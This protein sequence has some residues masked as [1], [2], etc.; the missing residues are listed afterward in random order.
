[1][2]TDATAKKVQDY[3]ALIGAI[4]LLIVWARRRGRP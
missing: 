2:I 3:A 1:M 4:A